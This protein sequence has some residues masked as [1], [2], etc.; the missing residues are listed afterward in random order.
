MKWVDVPSDILRRNFELLNNKLSFGEIIDVITNNSPKVFLL[1][2]VSEK[3]DIHLKSSNNELGG[4]LI[5]NFYV[6]DHDSVKV[7]VIKDCIEST[8][9]KSTSVSLEMTT[10]IW[11]EVNK[12]TNSI[13]IVV[14]WYHSH[15]NLGAF[16]SGTDR[17]TQSHFFNNDYSLGLVIDP[18]KNEEKWFLSENSEEVTPNRINKSYTKF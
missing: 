17:Y 6:D 12:I 13:D 8:N 5:G 1:K 18:I 10:D 15:P 7:I 3:V 11:S 2:K 16:F 14:G 4:I 9:F